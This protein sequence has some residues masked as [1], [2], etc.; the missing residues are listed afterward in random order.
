M[1]NFNFFKIFMGNIFRC[2][3]PKNSYN[4]L[5]NYIY[6]D[7]CKKNTNHLNDF[8]KISNNDPYLSNDIN[9]K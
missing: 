2:C 8:Y 9:I 5:E 4:E 6:L 3:M 1:F 7:K